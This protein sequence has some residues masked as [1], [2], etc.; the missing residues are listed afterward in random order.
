M[1][2]PHPFTRCRREGAGDHNPRCVG[3]GHASVRCRPSSPGVCR[4]VAYASEMR[5][6]QSI[7]AVLSGGGRILCR[8]VGGREAWASFCPLLHNVAAGIDCRDRAG[9]G[10]LSC[11]RGA[12]A[13]QPNPRGTEGQG[14]GCCWLRWG[15][16]GG[17]HSHGVTPVP[18]CRQQRVGEVPGGRVQVL[19][20]PLD[21]GAG[22]AH[23]QL[24][25][26]RAG[27]GARRG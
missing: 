18:A 2:S 13:K 5:S 19:R 16:G 26:G 6:L 7:P 24:V 10:P 3:H 14:D 25:P 4:P 21:V 27:V 9:S 23:L 8:V 12:K 11:R 22:A 15:G 20:A 1:A 17:W